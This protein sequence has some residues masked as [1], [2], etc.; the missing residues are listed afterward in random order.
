M[1]QSLV[2]SGDLKDSSD[3]QKL[4]RVLALPHFHHHEKQSVVK[5]SS[6]IN[7]SGIN[8]HQNPTIIITDD[9][10]Q[11]GLIKSSH[12]HFSNLHVDDLTGSAV[13]VKPRGSVDMTP[14][15]RAETSSLAP[16]TTKV[17]QTL[18]SSLP[19]MISF[20]LFQNSTII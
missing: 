3:A 14:A 1:V 5:P 20:S 17:N 10:D 18:T 13:L 9:T 19:S 7:T 2:D 4:L 11:P 6:S 12:F 15:E 16:S 8:L